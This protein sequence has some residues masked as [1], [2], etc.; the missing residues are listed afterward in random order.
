MPVGDKVWNLYGPTETTVWATGHQLTEESLAGESSAEISVP[1][2]KAVPGLTAHVIKEDGAYAARGEQGEL[3]IGGAGVA[4]GYRGN[5]ALTAERFV[6]IHGERVYRTGDIVTEDTQGVLH[7]YGRNDEQLSV[8]GVRVEPGEVEAAILKNNGVAQAAVTWFQTP[9]GGRAI[10]AAV[11]LAPDAP[12]SA[13]KL[14]EALKTWLPLQMIPARFL[15]V[16]WL[17]VNANGKIDRNA[18]RQAALASPEDE[19]VQKKRTEK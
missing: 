5:P 17:P 10:V 2:G 19:P 9:T 16:P 6:E 18:I 13:S 12:P 11:V 3:W 4:R 1:I 8:R 7:Y 14:H 15:F